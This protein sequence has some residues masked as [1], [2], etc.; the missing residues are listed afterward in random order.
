VD[1]AF[2]KQ[3]SNVLSIK[4]KGKQSSENSITNVKVVFLKGD[5]NN[6]ELLDAVSKTAE[7]KSASK[8]SAKADNKKPDF[9][10]LEKDLHQKL[11]SHKY[12]ALDKETSTNP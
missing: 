12:F 5:H 3:S 9:I 7:Q 4:I 10:A 11:E 2:K 1:G 6:K 8:S